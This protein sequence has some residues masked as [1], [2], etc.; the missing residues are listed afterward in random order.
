MKKLLLASA[1]AALS[2]S[3]ANAA[4][5]VYGKAYLTVDASNAKATSKSGIVQT[6]EDTN[7]SGLN[8]NSSR[9]GL[10]GSEALTAD[11]DVVYQLE[12]GINIDSGDDT[13]SQVVG[14]KP[15][16]QSGNVVLDNNGQVQYEP[17][18]GDKKVKKDQFYARDTY[19]GLAH[20]QYGTLLAGRLTT[21]DDNVDFASVL[22][23]NNVADIGPTFGA[24]R[25]N[26]AFAYVSPE[27]NGAQ[28]LGM[29]AFDSDT[30]EGGLA[31]DD[32]FGVGATYSTGPINA[33]ATYI[34]Y[35]DDNH[36]RLS[37]NYAVSPALTVGALYQISK[38]GV[39]AK[40]QKASPLNDGN[41]GDKKENTLIVSG[42]MKTATPWTAYGQVTLVKN[43]AGV[44]GEKK[45]GVG[46]GGKYA[47][48]KATTGHV[49]TGYIN[50]DGRTYKG[51]NKALKDTVYESSKNTGFSVGAG[52]EYRF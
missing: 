7:E 49:Y 13:V 47:F 22:E 20:K 42:E 50:E 27:Y 40:N 36:I 32:Q 45:M 26:N 30:D 8:S 15:K 2:V 23:G 35:G 18:F 31:K 34:H 12:Y 41:V 46:V 28:F 24:P 17:V 19:L 44:D 4:P 14:V 38:F 5:T 48:N 43:A 51:K 16:Y 6:K 39:A 3:A 9:I 33:G 1:V 21:I 37:G 52:V 25:A 11:I 29:Y 10:K